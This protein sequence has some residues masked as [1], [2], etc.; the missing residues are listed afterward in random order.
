MAGNCI[1]FLSLSVIVD[2]DRSGMGILI[3]N[4]YAPSSKKA[5]VSVARRYACYLSPYH[6]R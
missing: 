4:A 6:L 1:D 5:V 3:R 2:G